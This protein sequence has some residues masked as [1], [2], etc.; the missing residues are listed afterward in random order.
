MKL[1]GQIRNHVNVKY[2]NYVKYVKYVKVLQEWTL[3]F[4]FKRATVCVI[5]HRRPTSRMSMF[6]TLI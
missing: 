6:I 3:N 2:V 1:G 5:R 4:L